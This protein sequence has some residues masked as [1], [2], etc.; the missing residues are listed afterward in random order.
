M[1]SAN[2]VIFVSRIVFF[3]SLLNILEVSFD[4]PFSW[5]L[6]ISYWFITIWEF[7]E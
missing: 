7:D 6:T 2:V 5:L 3:F 1:M 4:N